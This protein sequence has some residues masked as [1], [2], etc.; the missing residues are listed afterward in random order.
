MTAEHCVQVVFNCVYAQ[1]GASF[2]MQGCQMDLRVGGSE[3]SSAQ[4]NLFDCVVIMAFIPV[5]DKLVFPGIE[6][7]GYKMTLLRKVHGYECLCV[8]GA[9]FVCTALSV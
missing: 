5:F 3:I 1:M 2:V 7:L 6:S 8:G 4:L 9:C